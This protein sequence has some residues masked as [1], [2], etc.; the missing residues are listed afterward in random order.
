MALLTFGFDLGAKL[1]GFVLRFNLGCLFDGLGLELSIIEDVLR[2]LGFLLCGGVYQIASDHETEGY[3]NE[4]TNNC[5]GKI[6]HI[7]LI[8]TF[9][10]RL[11][12]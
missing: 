1:Q 12:F 7:V 6:R 5:D 4:S 10:L 2:L 9:D 3:A 8:S 11:R